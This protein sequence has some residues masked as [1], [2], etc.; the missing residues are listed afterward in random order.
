MRKKGLEPS[1]AKCPLEPESSS[2]ANS[3]TSANRMIFLQSSYHSVCG[4]W[5]LN[6]HDLTATRSLVLLV[7]QFR[8]FRKPFSVFQRLNDDYYNTESSI[9]QYFFQTFFTFFE[10]DSTKSHTFQKAF[11]ALKNSC[12]HRSFHAEEGT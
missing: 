6:P 7:C 10:T 4:R 2:S 5:D 3:D 9:R 1:R 12:T 8:H 11:P